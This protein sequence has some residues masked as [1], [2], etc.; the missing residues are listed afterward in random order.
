MLQPEIYDHYKNQFRK[1]SAQI[2]EEDI[3]EPV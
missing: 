3:L 2:K 1:L